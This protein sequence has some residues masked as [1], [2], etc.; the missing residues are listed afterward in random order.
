MQGL[1]LDSG[2]VRRAGAQV[3]YL[4]ESKQV[5]Y[6]NESLNESKRAQN[7]GERTQT[8]LDFLFVAQ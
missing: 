6:L 2:L 8:R 1:R 4:N 7:E 5:P 3:P